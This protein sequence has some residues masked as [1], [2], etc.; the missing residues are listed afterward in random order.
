MSKIIQE[1]NI[2]KELETAANKL[3]HD[4][5]LKR[6]RKINKLKERLGSKFTESKCNQSIKIAKT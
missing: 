3:I 6:Q 5:Q 4:K 2:N 1:F